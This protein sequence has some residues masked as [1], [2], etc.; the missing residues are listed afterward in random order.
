MMTERQRELV[1]R[2]LVLELR[3]VR[4]NI[5]VYNQQGCQDDGMEKA[6]EMESAL[7]AALKELFDGKG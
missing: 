2:I 1:M 3:T 4:A 6:K 7:V 5:R